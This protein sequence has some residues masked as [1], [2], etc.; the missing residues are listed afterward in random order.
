MAS[1]NA[2]YNLI[3]TAGRAHLPHNSREE[4]LGFIGSAPTAQNRKNQTRLDGA[5]SIKRLEGGR[6]AAA[7]RTHDDVRD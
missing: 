1:T 2:V 7:G 3:P 5:L 4:V 6:E